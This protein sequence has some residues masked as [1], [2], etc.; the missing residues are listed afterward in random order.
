MSSI[1]T[2]VFKAT[3]GLLVNKGRDAAAERLKD[4]DVTDQKFRG[5]IVREIQDLKSK[6]DGLSRKDLLSAVDF[7]EAGV[8]YLYKSIDAAKRSGEVSLDT[9]RASRENFLPSDAVT[10][11]SLAKGMKNMQLAE[12]HETAKSALSQAKERFKM[13]REKAT[14]ASNNEAL[15]TFERIAAIRY[16]VMATMLESAVDTVGAASDL[17]ALSVKSALGNAL[18]ECEQCLLKLHSLPAVQ[19]S[20]KVEFQKGLNLRGRFGKDERMGMIST[21]CQ[22][23]RAVY[24]AMQTVGKDVDIWDWP[25]VDIGEDKVDPLRD[26]R[27]TKALRKIGMEHC[28]ITWSFGQEDEEEHKLKNP[29]GITVNTHGQFLI[30]DNGDKTVKLFDSSGNFFR[31]FYPQADEAES[32]SWCSE[33]RRADAKLNVDDVACDVENNT[34]VLVNLEIPG[35]LGYEAE[36]HVFN[37]TANLHHKFPVRMGFGSFKNRLAVGDSKVFVLRKNGSFYFVDVYEHDGRYVCKFEKRDATDIAVAYDGRIWVV[38]RAGCCYHCTV[39][40]QQVSKFNANERD[41][42]YRI[43]CQPAGELVFLA[44]T[45]RATRRPQRIAIFT[46][47]GEFVRLI[48]LDEEISFRGL[49]AITATKDGR[50]AVVVRDV[51]DGLHKVIVV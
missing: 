30:A 20:F 33:L 29:S 51:H 21:V 19:N 26:G 3:I 32:S 39:E 31:S 50:I 10:T 12:L 38:D 27:V 36:V 40:G 8:R 42:F 15:S 4:G 11:V 16:R 24:D 37:D 6:L 14:E 13:A 7:F 46:N 17:S 35:Y 47:D 28:C 23:N 5:L 18:P 48:Q 1:I 22:V 25:Y 9:Q 49:I 45:E 41:H 44:C 2:A 34:Y 43:A